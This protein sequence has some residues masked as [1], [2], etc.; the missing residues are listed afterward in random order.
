MSG[1]CD[2]LSAFFEDTLNVDA[3]TDGQDLFQTGALDSIGIIELVFYLENRYKVH[4]DLD[5]LEL[6]NIRTL[7]A[8]RRYVETSL[9][10]SESS[11]S[12]IDQTL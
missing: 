2:D 11:A 6:D 8:I 4:L 3:P 5:A 7:S 12:R 1:I 9:P 10:S